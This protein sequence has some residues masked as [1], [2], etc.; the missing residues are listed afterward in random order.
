MLKMSRGIAILVVVGILFN[1]NEVNGGFTFIS[2]NII[3]ILP[4]VQL[5]YFPLQE[6]IVMMQDI[7]KQLRVAMV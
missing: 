3:V 5:S 4:F 2:G 1:I 6:T 7:V